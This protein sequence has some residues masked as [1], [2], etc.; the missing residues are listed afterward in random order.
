MHQITRSPSNAA[1][2]KL[3]LLELVG[4]FLDASLGARLVA[5]LVVAADPD[6]ADGVVADIDRIAAAQRNHLGEL[7]LTRVLLAGV[8][9]VAPLQRRAAEGAGG[10]GLAAIELQAMRARIVGRNEYAHAA[11]A[12]SR[13]SPHV[14]SFC[15]CTPPSA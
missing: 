8:G 10:V 9:A 6:A 12:I 7:A 11:G 5:G 1:D 3:A 14:M 13:P 15:V 4:N 2:P